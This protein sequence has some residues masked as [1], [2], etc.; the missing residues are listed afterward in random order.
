M[1]SNA[2]TFSGTGTRSSDDLVAKYARS[3]RRRAL[4][5]RE[6]E[7]ELA[8]RIEG[9]ATELRALEAEAHEHARATPTAAQR[10]E[11][12]ARVAAARRRLVRAKSEMAEANLRLV[13]SIARRY[14]GRSLSRLDLIQEGNLGLLIAVDR[15]DYRR[16]LKF[17]TY[18]TWWIRQS[19]VRALANTDRTIRLPVHTQDK[20][21]RL[22]RAH[23]RLADELGRAPSFDELAQRTE[24]PVEMVERLLRAAT[25]VLSLEAPIDDRH[26]VADT[27]ATPPAVDPEEALAAERAEQQ[28]HRLLA[29]L[30]ARARRILRRRYGLDGSGATLRECS[31]RFSLSRERVRQLANSALERMRQQ[32]PPRV[33]ADGVAAMEATTPEG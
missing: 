15:F 24:I 9:A 4:L 13:V 28:V 29:G 22:H 5:T 27:L 20:L 12:E 25:D 32:A 23:R 18:A 14:Q 10:R 1:L 26:T 11:H 33:L 30:D 3:I 8:K 31:E 6:G 21:V 7:V 17:S 2:A 19:I 16:G